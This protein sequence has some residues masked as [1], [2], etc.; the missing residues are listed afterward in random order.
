MPRNRFQ[1]AALL[2]AALAFP[3]TAFALEGAP[4]DGN[5]HPSVG[6]LFA[7]QTDPSTCHGEILSTCSA[8]LLSSTVLVTTGSCA[9]QFLH[10][11]EYGYTLTAIWIS[12]NPD[13]S[14]DCS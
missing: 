5:Q 8:T 10:P 2:C 3:A 4:L 7:Q 11:E 9:D 12:F 14:F 1:V 13:N 6:Y